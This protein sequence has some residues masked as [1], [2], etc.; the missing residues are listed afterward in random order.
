MDLFAA[1]G[2]KELFLMIMQR[3]QHYS[4]GI[5]HST[6]V[7]GS[8]DRNVQQSVFCFFFPLRTADLKFKLLIV[9]KRF[10]T[11]Y[12]MSHCEKA[13]FMHQVE[14]DFSQR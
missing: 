8:D 1:L 13:I 10:H 12:R 7:V 6:D 11:K 3:Q 2:I 14:I 5:L 4:L 9:H